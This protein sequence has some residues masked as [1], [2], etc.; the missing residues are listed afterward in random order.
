MSARYGFYNVVTTLSEAS[1]ID[2]YSDNY[3]FLFFTSVEHSGM[4]AAII[5]AQG[6]WEYR[7]FQTDCLE[8]NLNLHLFDVE[9]I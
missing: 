7:M 1:V 4:F 3:P 2:V 9:V 8:F 6:R 5:R